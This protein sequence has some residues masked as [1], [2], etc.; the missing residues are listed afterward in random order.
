[1]ILA[2]L[3]LRQRNLAP[4]LDANGWAV[5]TKAKINIPFGSSLTC[6][7][8]L[9]EGSQRSLIDPYA[10]KE[11]P[12]KLYAALIVGALILLFLARQGYL[13]SWLMRLF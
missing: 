7:A 3:N 13:S 11:R 4:I 2:Y 8:K 12:W 1:M 9:P 5:N 6:L 10:E